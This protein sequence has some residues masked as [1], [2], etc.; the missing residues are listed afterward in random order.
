L[1][2]RVAVGSLLVRPIVP[3]GYWLGDGA[4][5]SLSES[6]ST[7]P[8]VR[9][10]TRYE[11][12]PDTTADYPKPWHVDT[13]AESGDGGHTSQP[14]EDDDQPAPTSF[15]VDATANLGQSSGDANIFGALDDVFPSTSVSQGGGGAGLPDAAPFPG[16]EAAAAS[17]GGAMATTPRDSGATASSPAASDPYGGGA[18]PSG[19][20]GGGGS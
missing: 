15:S 19:F 4:D 2:D 10:V 7:E 13:S 18:V 9:A 14:A 8:A 11:P 5:N 17:T 20:G 3:D 16:G 1:E 6:I 12:A